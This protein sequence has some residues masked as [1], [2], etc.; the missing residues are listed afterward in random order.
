MRRLLPPASADGALTDDEL[1]HEY[2]Y[3]DGVSWLRANMVVSL[4]G[5]ASLEG[6]SEGLSG[7]A[8]KRVFFLLRNLADVVIVGA[9]TARAENYGGVRVREQ[10]AELRAS[11]GQA[12]TPPV[13]IVSR[14]LG[15][16][17][18]FLTSDHDDVAGPR[19]RGLGI[20]AVVADLPE[21]EQAAAVRR[22][23][24]SGCTVAVVGA[25]DSPTVAADVGMSFTAAGVSSVTLI[26]PGLPAAVEVLRLGRRAAVVSRINAR[27]AIGGTSLTACAAAGGLVRPSLAVGLAVLLAVVLTSRSL[28]G[29]HDTVGVLAPDERVT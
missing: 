5:V 24:D 3:P 19:A 10:Y 22:L 28:A 17:P 15:L 20:D 9:G 1:A 8:D 12:P 6:L 25:S 14:R 4:D 16:D 27:L 13:A 23:Q 18:V 29:F 26:D 7:E 11:L 21:E 2:R